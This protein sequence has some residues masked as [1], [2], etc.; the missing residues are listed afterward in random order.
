MQR[1]S[2]WSTHPDSSC[3]TQLQSRSVDELLV[4]CGGAKQTLSREPPRALQAQNPVVTTNPMFFGKII[5]NNL[6]C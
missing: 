1:I 4:F 3:R 6:R 2:G 5:S